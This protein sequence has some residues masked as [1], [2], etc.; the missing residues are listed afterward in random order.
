MP[1]ESVPA[2]P[3][4]YYFLFHS[5]Y[6]FH[7]RRCRRLPS[8]ILFSSSI[9]QPFS[10]YKFQISKS[11]FIFYTSQFKAS[12]SWSRAFFSW[13]HF[14]FLP[15]VTLWILFICEVSMQVSLYI[16]RFK[17][18]HS[19]SFLFFIFQFVHSKFS[20][21]STLLNI[22]DSDIKVTNSGAFC[23]NSIIFGGSALELLKIRQ[24][25]IF[26]YKFFQ[27]NETAHRTTKLL[28]FIV[29]RLK[30][31]S[32]FAKIYSLIFEWN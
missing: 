26:I 27:R 3:L 31:I 17:D 6:S 29:F 11:N 1:H 5:Y 22:L 25:I 7:W 10:R 14:W 13:I 28:Q 9:C 8:L 20:I 24:K 15:L 19:F 16:Y 4:F 2:N 23:I 18:S 21:N 30:S 32:R 12:L